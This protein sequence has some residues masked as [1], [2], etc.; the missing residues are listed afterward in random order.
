MR[1]GFPIA[2]RGMT[3][4]LLGGSFDPAHEGHV[5][6]TRE[7]LRRFG[8]DRVWWLVTPGNPLKA[9]QPAPMA[10]RLARARAL[11]RHPRVVVTDLEAHLGTRYTAATIRRLQAIY[12]GVNFVWLMGADNLVQFHRWDRWEQI[13][14]AVPVGVL[15]RPGWGVKGRMG[16]AARVYARERVTE[17]AAGDLGLLRPPVWVLADVPLNDMSSSAI[18]ARG[19]WGRGGNAPPG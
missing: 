4:G 10:E 3:V 18:R 13:M 5:H 6:I 19:E 17:G 9:R 8:L 1:Q 15:A 11:M 7:A 2:T 12:P 14:Q 16:R